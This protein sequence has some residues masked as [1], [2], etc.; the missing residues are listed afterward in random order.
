M[1]APPYL[2][3]KPL[4]NLSKPFY[5]FSITDSV[6]VKKPWC[7]GAVYLL[8][9]D[10]FEQEPAQNFQGV[11][12]IFPHWIG[13]STVDPIGKLEV[14]PEDFPFLDQIRGHD[15]KKLLAKIKADPNGFP[16]V[17]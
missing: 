2:L 17:D 3:Q 13:K 14:G 12:V 9:R 4:V 10:S 11:E 15:E 16:W 8:P 6:L 1:Q 7:K 5:F